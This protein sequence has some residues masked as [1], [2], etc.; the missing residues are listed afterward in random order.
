MKPVDLGFGVVGYEPDG[1]AD[2]LGSLDSADLRALGISE[3][4]IDS[5]RAFRARRAARTSIT[6]ADIADIA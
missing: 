4:V 3:G 2:R 5:Y 1:N 6:T